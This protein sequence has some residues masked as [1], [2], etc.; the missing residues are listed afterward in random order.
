MTINENASKRSS[1]RRLMSSKR[2][3]WV[4]AAVAAG[5]T[6]TGVS[7]GLAASPATSTS[8]SPPST[9][10]ASA[11]GAAA[12]PAG[13]GGGGGNARSGPAS[14]GAVGTVSAM[15]SSGFTLTTSAGQKVTVNE[16]PTTT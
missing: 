2:G 10:T 14:G 6:A 9:A 5:V 4:V 3:R 11:G 7:V 12:G 1:Y 15:S 8:T 13:R 16:V